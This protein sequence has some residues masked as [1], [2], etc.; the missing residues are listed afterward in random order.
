MIIKRVFVF[1]LFFYTKISA[2][3]FI[4]RNDW[5]YHPNLKDIKSASI[6]DN[7]IYPTGKVLIYSD[8]RE[9]KSGGVNFIGQLFIADIPTEGTKAK[10]GSSNLL[11]S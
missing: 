6:Y 7:K 2:Q 9:L 8:F 4:E 10:R 5:R 11:F 1:I 3:S